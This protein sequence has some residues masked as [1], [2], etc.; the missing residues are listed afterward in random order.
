[1]I[2]VFNIETGIQI[3]S[4]GGGRAKYPWSRLEIRQSFIVPCDEWERERTFNTLTSC[5]RNAERRGKKFTMRSVDRG[6]RVWRIL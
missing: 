2:E 3:P 4:R 5:K 1:M 6:I